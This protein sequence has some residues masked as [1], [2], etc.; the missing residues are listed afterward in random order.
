MSTL[1]H[2]SG[3]LHNS[4]KKVASQL[5]EFWSGVM[6][7]GGGGAECRRYIESLPLLAKV[8]TTLPLLMKSLTTTI[9]T[10]ALESL[11]AASST[12]KDDMPSQLL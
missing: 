6:A 5:K 11:K 9:V 10:A 12:R 8:R 7:G 4:P 1:R 2:S 3:V